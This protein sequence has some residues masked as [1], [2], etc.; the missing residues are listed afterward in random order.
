MPCLLYNG[1]RFTCILK[2]AQK[3]PE[4]HVSSS[5]FLFMHINI[6]D[7]TRGPYSFTFILFPKRC[8]SLVY[9]I[10]IL[11]QVVAMW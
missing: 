3:K 6:E 8:L 9:N 11:S 1:A 5:S 10:F 4:N 7:Y 2:L